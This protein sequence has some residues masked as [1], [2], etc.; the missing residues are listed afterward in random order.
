[1]LACGLVIAAGDGARVQLTP[2]LC[3]AFTNAGT[4]TWSED[5]VKKCFLS[6]VALAFWP[7]V[8]T[9]FVHTGTVDMLDATKG[10]AAFLVS[11]PRVPAALVERVGQDLAG[12]T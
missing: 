7:P 4:W 12:P 2:R 1:M 6:H 9:H 8:H 10:S 11:S 5:M 3:Q